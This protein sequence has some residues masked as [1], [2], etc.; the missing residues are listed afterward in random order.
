MPEQHKSVL[1]GVFYEPIHS[2]QNISASPQLDVQ[3]YLANASQENLAF[4]ILSGM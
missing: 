3:T 4:S 2:G 1:S